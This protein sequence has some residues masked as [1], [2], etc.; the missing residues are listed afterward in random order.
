MGVVGMALLSSFSGG[1]TVPLFFAAAVASCKAA[2][3]EAVEVLRGRRFN[4][5]SL[6]G[7]RLRLFALFVSFGFLS[8]AGSGS[9]FVD[10]IR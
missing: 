9:R 2:I 4:G 1:V 3:F 10:W 5:G 8:V 7:C 6:S